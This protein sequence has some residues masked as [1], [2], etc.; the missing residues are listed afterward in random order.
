MNDQVIEKET[1]K[2]SFKING[3]DCPACAV[4]IQNALL[5]KEGVISAEVSLQNAEAIVEIEDNRV[6]SEILVD[7]IELLGYIVVV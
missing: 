6:N 2:L 1:R 5:R 7:A 3:M 4:R